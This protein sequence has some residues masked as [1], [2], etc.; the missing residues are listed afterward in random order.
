MFKSGIYHITADVAVILEQDQSVEFNLNLEIDGSAPLIGS[1]FD[2]NDI[3]TVTGTTVQTYL[4]VGDEIGIFI[5]KAFAL[6]GKPPRYKRA[7][8]T[9]HLL[10]S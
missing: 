1:V 2:A 10:D 6:T 7:G 5:A 9:V 8:L 3:S 4:N